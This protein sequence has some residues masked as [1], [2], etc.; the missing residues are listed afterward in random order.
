MSVRILVTP[1]SL[2]DDADAARAVLAPLRERGWE[3]VTAPAGRVPTNAELHGLVVGVDGWLAGVEHIGPDVLD[4]A[5]RLRVI[6]RNG[7]GADGVD[8]D[9]AASRGVEVLLA[10]GANSRGVAELAVALVLASLRGLPAAHA[11]LHD[12][13][14]ERTLGREVADLT[15]GVVGLGAIGRLV[16]AITGAMGA[17]VIGSD[18][19][20]DPATA[21]VP[22]VPL[23]EL[24]ARSDVVSLHTP[25]A[26]DGRPVVDAALLA[27]MPADGVLVNTARASLVDDA[28]VLVA[29]ESGALRGYAVDAFDTEPP[30]PTPLLRHPRTITTP[31]LGGY[32][33]ASTRRAASA[34][35]ANLVASL[36]R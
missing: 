29:L 7:V 36:E 8:L 33:D 11:A 12:G 4:R 23:D 5:D 34:A 18:P 16:A 1:R 35:V 10:R 25:P 30:E 26:A 14:W 21:P 6:S 27:S 22:V 20:V 2:T 17:T 24:F 9:A 28:A 19:F 3:V 13:R 32:T 31:H 15:V